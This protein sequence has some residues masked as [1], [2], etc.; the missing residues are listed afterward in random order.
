M[1]APQR[2]AEAVA[3]MQVAVRVP[4]TVKCRIG[5]DDQDQSEFL[6]HF[7]DTVA[8]SGCT[9]FIVHARKAIS[10]GLTPRQNRD[11]P[12]L[13]YDVVYRLKSERPDSER[14]DE[15]LGS[16]RSMRPRGIA[17]RWTVS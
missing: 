1:A 6:L 14:R 7:I 3:A 2:V 4:V 16:A 17:V 15:W 13:R 12:P 9:Q 8:A 10:T 5:I 11:I